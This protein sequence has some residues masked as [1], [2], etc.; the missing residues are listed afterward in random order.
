MNSFICFFSI[1]PCSSRCSCALSLAKRTMSVR[2]PVPS[3]RFL[4]SVMSSLTHPFCYSNQFSSATVI[5]Q[6]SLLLCCCCSGSGACVEC[7]YVY[8]TAD[9]FN[10]EAKSWT[11]AA[12][13]YLMPCAEQLSIS[14][15]SLLRDNSS[16][17]SIKT[18][19]LDC[20][21]V[22]FCLT[23]FPYSSPPALELSF[24]AHRHLSAA[25]PREA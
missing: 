9:N 4:K 16:K 19:L 6:S 5:R 15:S 12:W 25:N 11:T 8:S 24:T 14:H 20:R 7:Q 3:K 21:P 10:M 13:I 1:R 23:A 18:R 2:S 22:L 17:G